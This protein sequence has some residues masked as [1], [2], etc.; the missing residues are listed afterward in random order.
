M[1]AVLLVLLP[2]PAFADH[3]GEY[4]R[5]DTKTIHVIDSVR[6][7]LVK[8]KARLWKRVRRRVLADYS[9]AGFTF[10]WSLGPPCRDAEWTPRDGTIA[11]CL[12]QEQTRLGFTHHRWTDY[13]TIVAATAWVDRSC[14]VV[15]HEFGHA[16]GLGHRSDDEQSCINNDHTERHPDAHD[17]EALTNT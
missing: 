16:L 13:P 17:L 5:W 3:G 8:K 10:S 9:A 14:H 4:G 12:A 6:P 1:V 2:V 11:L 7:T 15:C